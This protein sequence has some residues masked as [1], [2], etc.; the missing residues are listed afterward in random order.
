MLA[1]LSS[2][3]WCNMGS[4]W[5]KPNCKH[6]KMLSA[7]S[8]WF[9]KRCDCS[10]M[11]THYS[12]KLLEGDAGSSSVSAGSFFSFSLFLL[13]YN[14]T[15]LFYIVLVHQT[16]MLALSAPSLSVICPRYG[17][18]LTWRLLLHQCQNLIKIEWF[19]SL[20]LRVVR[21]H[22]HLIRSFTQIFFCH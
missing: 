21:K 6:H 13:V 4:G 19:V 18:N 12:Q 15:K 16:D 5:S 1:S 14:F 11:W 8:I 2:F 3:H 22:S 7:V 20:S 9:K 10:A 17:R